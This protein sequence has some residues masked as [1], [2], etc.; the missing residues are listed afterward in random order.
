MGRQHLPEEAVVH[1]AWLVRGDVGGAIRRWG[2][3]V[4]TVPGEESARAH[5]C[6]DDPKL[7]LRSSR[8]TGEP[9][10]LIE[11][12]QRW[13]VRFCESFGD[14]PIHHFDGGT[15]REFRA[16]FLGLGREASDQVPQDHLG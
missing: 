8:K 7:G 2:A 3:A 10:E 6:W 4:L 13:A 16:W 9:H 5:H 14:V 1:R 12:A 11:S 15:F